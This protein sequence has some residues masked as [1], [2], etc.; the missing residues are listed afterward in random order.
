MGSEQLTTGSECNSWFLQAGSFAANFFGVKRLEV[1]QSTEKKCMTQ[2]QASK[3]AL[4]AVLDKCK[5]NMAPSAKGGSKAQN[6]CIAHHQGWKKG[7]NTCQA[8]SATSREYRP[9]DKNE[10][11]AFCKEMYST[12]K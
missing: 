9:Q 11:H 2:K 1:L 12:G 7:P 10:C 3:G 8:C 6:G 4:A 5:A